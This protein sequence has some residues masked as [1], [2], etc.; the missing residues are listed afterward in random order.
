MRGGGDV[1][2]RANFDIR[3]FKKCKQKA[4]TEMN[5]VGADQD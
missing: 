3:N 5:C 1:I 4:E 2:V